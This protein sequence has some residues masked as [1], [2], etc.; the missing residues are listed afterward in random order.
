M[1]VLED[2]H[3]KCSGS[4]K[5]IAVFVLNP[6]KEDAFPDFV[7]NPHRSNPRREE[8]SQYDRLRGLDNPQH[9]RNP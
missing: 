8:W 4:G 5:K 2:T 9:A 3:K 6:N 7:G 1:L